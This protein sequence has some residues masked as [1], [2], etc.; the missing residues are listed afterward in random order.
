MTYSAGRKEELTV[1]F[2]EDLSTTLDIQQTI[3]NLRITEADARAVIKF[4]LKERPPH[5]SG[6][7]KSTAKAKAEAGTSTGRHEL[8][9][10]GASRGN[11]GPAGAGALIKD[12]SAK[13]LRRLK[14]FL[15]RTT[16]NVAEYSALVLGLEA[17]RAM[18][19]ERLNVFADSELMVKQLNGVYKVKSEDLRPLFEKASVLSKGFKEFSIRHIYREKNA[20]ADALSNEAIDDRPKTLFEHT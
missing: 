18:G 7:V 8:Y 2:L 17:A 14:K 9:V 15:G 1:R 10:D 20:A 4:L 5:V 13:V 3:E 11:P 16:N 12:P 6:E 19:V